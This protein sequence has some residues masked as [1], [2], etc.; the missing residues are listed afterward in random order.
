MSGYKVFIVDDEADI[1]LILKLQLEDAGY[2]TMRARDGIEALDA[3]ER[4]SF[5][6]VLLDIRMP[7]MDGIE[8]LER[9]RD[10][11]PDLVV[12]MMTAHGS[13]DIAVEAMKKGAVDYISKPFSSDDMKKRVERAI[14]FNRTRLEN[15]RLQRVLDEERRKMG[16]ILRGMA[17]LLVAVDR[18]GRIITINRAAEERFGIAADGVQNQPVELLLKTDIPGERLPCRVVLA[19]GDPCLDVTYAVQAGGGMI[20]VLSSATPLKGAGGEMMGC[21]E[22]IRDISTLKALERE[23]EDF[24]SMLS[25]DLKTPITA[26]VG[27]IDLVREGRIGPVNAEQRSYL[28]SAME[29]C[30]EM[31]D[32][33]DTLLDVHR[34]EAGRMVMAARLEDLGP[35]MART[36]GR[37]DSVARRAGIALVLTLPDYPL[38]LSLDRNQFARLMGNLIANAIKFT[39]EGGE[40]EVSARLLNDPAELVG[41]IPRE[42]YPDVPLPPLNPHL[43]ITVRDT[44]VGIPADSLVSIF[45]RF[46]QARNRRLGKSTGTGLGLAFCRK[47]MD[48]HH[49]YIWA[50]SVEGEGSSFNMLFPLTNEAYAATGG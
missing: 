16:A 27:S 7:R 33:I 4:E 43:L 2:R 37:F 15:E 41:R 40:I 1:A 25:H 11:W 13:E 8:V 28:D 26:V 44:G 31:V 18:E 23:R 10:R 20:P 35:L 32:M 46:V 21:V 49:G 48:A 5:D 38:A 6:L 47:V 29:S 42:S 45:D 50:E 9:I 39:Q 24:V 12:I 22:I 14:Q 3:L 30:A 19:T 17:D 36:L 34:F